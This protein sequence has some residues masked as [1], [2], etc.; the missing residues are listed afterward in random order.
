[1]VKLDVPL[2]EKKNTIYDIKT[3][4]LWKNKIYDD[5]DLKIKKLNISFD[6]FFSS[7]FCSTNILILFDR[8]KK[9]LALE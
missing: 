6:I 3:V 9:F 2:N 8:F 7:H 1:M 5:Y 4:L